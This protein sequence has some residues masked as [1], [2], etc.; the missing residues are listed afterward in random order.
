MTNTKSWSKWEQIIQLIL[1]GNGGAEVKIFQDI[2]ITHNK[3]L[4][5][6]CQ[7]TDL[8]IFITKS[9][10]KGVPE[11]VRKSAEEISPKV[12]DYGTQVVIF[13]SPRSFVT[14]DFYS[15]NFILFLQPKVVEPYLML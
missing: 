10:E 7:L 12:I 1:E 8:K 4:Q 15:T 5:D 6:I 9:Y 2:C 13:I 14:P 11:Q 3:I